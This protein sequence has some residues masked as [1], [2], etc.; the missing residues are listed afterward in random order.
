MGSEINKE[1]SPEEYQM[2]EKHPKKC[3]ESLIIREIQ[4]KITLTFH[5]KPVRM[6]KI[7]N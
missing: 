6:A 4:I 7:K 3:S 5:L 2:A 1:L